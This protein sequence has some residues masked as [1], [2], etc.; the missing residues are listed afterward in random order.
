[1]IVTDA[2]RVGI[3]TDSPNAKLHLFSSGST[4]DLLFLET[5]EDS[6]SA[7]PVIKLKRNSSSPADA[8]YLGQL[9]FQGENDADQNVTYA[10]ITGKIGSV[11][12][13]SEQGIIEFANM[14]NGS[15]GITARLRHDSL[16]L[17]NSTNLTV[18]GDVGIGNTS[19]ND[20][21][22]D[23]DWETL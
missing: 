10:K 5:T 16:Q 14:K 4:D 1:M 2:G 6:N 19:P 13:G 7:S 18:D 21:L 9:K 12:D 20:A 15:S 11:T 23:R 8:D 3:G 17:V 22:S